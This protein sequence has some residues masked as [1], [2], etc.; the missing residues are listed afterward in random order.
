LSIRHEE[1][2]RFGRVTP[3]APPFRSAAL[4]GGKNAMAD[5]RFWN[6][7]PTGFPAPWR[8]AAS[9]TNGAWSGKAEELGPSWPGLVGAAA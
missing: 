1:E 8:R 6:E 9:L 7:A 3:T 4:L 5:K 2:F